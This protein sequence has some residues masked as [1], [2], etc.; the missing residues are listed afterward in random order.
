MGLYGLL[1]VV[2]CHYYVAF[3]LDTIICMQLFMSGVWPHTSN[4]C[5][6][7]GYYI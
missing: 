2:L 3:V 6:D 7:V 1:I 4:K 5:D